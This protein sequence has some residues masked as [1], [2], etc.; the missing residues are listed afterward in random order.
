MAGPLKKTLIDFWHMI[1]QE[2]PKTVIVL[3]NLQ[4]CNKAKFEQYWPTSSS[5]D[6]QYGPFHVSLLK[7]VMSS[8]LIIRNLSVQVLTSILNFF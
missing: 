5:E 2:K 4:E 6:Q 8:N 7:E 3:A 1:W